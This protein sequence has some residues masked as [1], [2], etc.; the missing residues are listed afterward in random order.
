MDLLK[1]VG[2]ELFERV[3]KA[4]K[5][6]F[7]GLAFLA[8]EV[9]VQTLAGTNIGWLHGAAGAALVLLSLY[10]PKVKVIEPG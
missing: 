3:F 2:S 8:V 6:T 10:K 4:Y 7:V 9:T 5:S 1:K